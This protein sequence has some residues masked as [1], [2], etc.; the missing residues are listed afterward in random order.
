MCVSSLAQL[1][2]AS[3]LAVIGPQSDPFDS[4]SFSLLAHRMAMSCQDVSADDLRVCHDER[5]EI[6]Y[7]SGEPTVA[8]RQV[9]ADGQSLML[10]PDGW[11]DWVGDLFLRRTTRPFVADSPAAIAE[12]YREWM[13]PGYRMYRSSRRVCVYN[14]SERFRVRAMSVINAVEDGVFRYFRERHF[15]VH[16]PRFPLVVLMFRTEREFRTFTGHDKGLVGLYNT[17]GNFIVVFE[18]SGDY[19]DKAMLRVVA[20]EAVHQTLT[21]IGVEPR[22]ARWPAWVCEGLAECLSQVSGGDDPVWLGPTPPPRTDAGIL[23]AFATRF[24][25]VQFVGRTVAREELNNGLQY[26][27]SWCLVHHLLEERPASFRLYLRSLSAR[28][29]FYSPLVLLKADEWPETLSNTPGELELFRRYF[30]TSPRRLEGEFR[31]HVA[32]IAR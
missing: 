6:D 30:G 8:L 29:P 19:D 32:R 21:N 17:W 1:F 15:P 11:F 25:R 28:E 13:G 26:L 20:H 7:G 14:C 31:E 4:Q 5:M 27:A 16:R 24:Q 12:R 23:D 18:E 9:Q 2:V 22:L 3:A 10:M